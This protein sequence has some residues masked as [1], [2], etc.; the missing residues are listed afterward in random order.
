MLLEK[1]A[2]YAI[3]EQTSR[4]PDEVWHHTKRCVID[5]SAA[6]LPGMECAPATVLMNALA[7]E[8]D[9]GRGQLPVYGRKASTR[10]AALIMGAGSHTVE[11]DDIYR[12]GG[13]H[14]GSP[15]ISAAL[16]AAQSVDA[17]GEDF[18]R[19]V[20]V[21][22]EISTR[23]CEAV[24]PSHYVYWHTTATIGCIGAAAAAATVLKCNREQFINAIASVVTHMAGLQQAFRSESMTKPMHAAHAADVGVMCALA[25]KHGLTGTPDMLEGEIGFGV[26]MSKN[27]DWSKATAGLGEKYNITEITFKNHGSC[28]HTFASIDGALVLKQKH[29]LTPE[30]IASVRL[31]TYG[32]ATEICGRDT[33]SS[34]FEGRFS[35]KFTVASALV[36]GSVRL[37]AYTPERL[38]D[39]KVKDL[40]T[41]I[42]LVEDPTLT[43][44]YPKQRASRVK[45]TLTD[46]R[47]LEF[48]QPYR[49]G[50]PEQL[51]TDDEVNAKFMELATPVLGEAKS[52]ALLAALWSAEKGK[53]AALP[54]TK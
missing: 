47:K 19:G 37:N 6:L 23:V 10:A 4:L 29:N 17:S 22:Y 16:A 34:A 13:Y 26:A 15:T 1:L 32:Q 54:F 20:I 28:G 52:K 30:Q 42:E 33:V 14:P 12:A 3:H 41:R 7:D 45:M 40:M 53:A 2:D 9:H 35:L 43:A 49:K 46:G 18:L 25:A 44:G 36:H 11:F 38:N 5:W 24:M 31:E 39:A 50:D 21:G 48:F 51:L 27:A 8:L